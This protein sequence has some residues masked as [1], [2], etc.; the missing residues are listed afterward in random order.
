LGEKDMKKTKKRTKILPVACIFAFFMPICIPSNA[1]AHLSDRGTSEL[2]TSID[3]LSTKAPENDGSWGFIISKEFTLSAVEY[4]WENASGEIVWWS[5]PTVDFTVIGIGKHVIHYTCNYS[6]YT[7]ELNVP[8]PQNGSFNGSND[9]YFFNLHKKPIIKIKV[10]TS[11]ELLFFLFKKGTW[12][13]KL[14][15][16]GTLVET[17]EFSIEHL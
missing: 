14:Y 3:T 15:I 16:D 13:G 7:Y 6:I 1:I 2:L 4:L 10:R 5:G 12:V 8:Q 11:D 9:L 17:E